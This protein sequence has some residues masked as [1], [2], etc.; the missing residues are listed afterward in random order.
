MSLPPDLHNDDATLVV[1]IPALLSFSSYLGVPFFLYFHGW[2][3][4]VV[5]VIVARL[6]CFVL[7]SL[8]LLGSVRRLPSWQ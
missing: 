1:Y 4:G 7:V 6:M 3:V 8:S 2:A 5:V